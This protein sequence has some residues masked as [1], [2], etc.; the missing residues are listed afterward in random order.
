MKKK[1]LTAEE[2]EKIGRL[3]D[4]MTDGALIVRYHQIESTIQVM[5]D[6]TEP[7]TLAGDILEAW[8]LIELE[9][10]PDPILGYNSTWMTNRYQIEGDLLEL[11]KQPNK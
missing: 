1:I 8:K 10:I 9:L 4:Y 7:I 11:T 3:L 5:K 2:K 6:G